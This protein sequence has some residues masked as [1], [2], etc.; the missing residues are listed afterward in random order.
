MSLEG[1]YDSSLNYNRYHKAVLCPT[2]SD[3]GGDEDGDDGG[4]NFEGIGSDSEIDSLPCSQADNIL[5]SGAQF[6]LKT[7]D[8]RK[9]TQVALD[10][11]ISDTKT[12]IQSTLEN[13]EKKLLAEVN[14]TETQKEEIR[15]IFCDETNTNPFQGLD[16]LHQQEKFIQEHFN[17]V[18]ISLWK[19][20]S[21]HFIH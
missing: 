17:F 21:T 14:L 19:V 2:S 8:G 9:I 6:I 7:R 16:T 10:G 11:I 12:I 18:V 3:E 13:V 20:Y 1:T 4:H 15:S 5:V